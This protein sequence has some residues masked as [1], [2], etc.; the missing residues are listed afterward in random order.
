MSSETDSRGLRIS[1]PFA[2]SAMPNTI[3]DVIGVGYNCGGD[4]GAEAI[5]L[6]QLLR[7]VS[8][9]ISLMSSRVRARS[10]M[11]RLAA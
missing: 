1:A 7:I 2:A 6:I 11:R 5:C 9:E 4:A 8:H 10:R 3:R